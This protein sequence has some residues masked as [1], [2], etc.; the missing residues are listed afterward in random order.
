MTI[1]FTTPLLLTCLWLP[2]TLVAQQARGLTLEECVALAQQNNARIKSSQYQIEFSRESRKAASDLGRASATLMRGQYNSLYTDNNL[3]VGQSIP[4]PTTIIRQ[5]QLGAEQIL[6]AEQFLK[7]QQNSLVYEVRSAYYHLLYLEAQS[8]LLVAQ[9]S[10]YENFFRVASARFRTGESTL[11]ERT[12]AE[13]QWLEIKNQVRVNASDIA[14][15]ENQLR[16]LLQI[17]ERVHASEVLHK[18]QFAL[19]S[20]TA[21]SQN[22]EIQW[23]AQQ[24]KISA[25]SHKVERS[26][27]MPDLMVGGFVQSLTGVQNI[28]GIDTFF[29]SSRKFTGFQFGLSI[30]LWIRPQI[31]RARSAAIQEKIASTN[32]NHFYVVLRGTFEQGLQETAK[33]NAS[34]AYFEE[35]A[36]VNAALLL[37]QAMKSFQKGEIEYFEYLQALRQSFGIRSGH[38]LALNLYN[39]SVIKLEFIAGS[40]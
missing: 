38:L 29:P 26:K 2:G 21:L 32:A 6:G 4:F 36:L 13:S 11:L 16:V 17:D 39:Q 1:R 9:D 18:R 34:L 3:T 31:A 15:A 24:V 37:D 33:N 19:L 7:V 28:N 10:L 5:F 8:K 27:I 35:S 25:A 12:S 14:I 30:P 40:F 20:D 22:P 23:W